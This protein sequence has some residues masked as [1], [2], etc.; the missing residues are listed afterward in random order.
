MPTLVRLVEAGS[1]KPNQEKV[2]RLARVLWWRYCADP[3]LTLQQVA[4]RLGLASREGARSIEAQALRIVRF[5]YG[6]ALRGGE[7]AAIDQ[8][9]GAPGGALRRAVLGD[10][11]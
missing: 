6:K 5:A 4:E 8:S 7:K 9:L 3:R 10:E 11:S 1:R 2:E